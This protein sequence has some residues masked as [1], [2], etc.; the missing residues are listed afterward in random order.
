M[1]VDA[2]PLFGRNG[3][4]WDFQG[5]GFSYQ[6]KPEAWYVDEFRIAETRGRV[7]CDPLLCLDSYVYNTLTKACDLQAAVRAV[8]AVR[9]RD[10]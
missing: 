7:A 4:T 5:H 10:G 3:T 6:L 8:R 2:A 9:V 1:K